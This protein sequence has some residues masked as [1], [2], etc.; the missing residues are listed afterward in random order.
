VHRRLNHPSR[1]DMGIPP[2]L[3]FDRILANGTGGFV[4]A[5]FAEVS[6]GSRSTSYWVRRLTESTY[7]HLCGYGADRFLDQGAALDP[8]VARLYVCLF[9]KA[10][11]T[12]VGGTES[13]G[14]NWQ[15]LESYD[16]ASGK[17]DHSLTSLRMPGHAGALWM[18]KLV[19]SSARANHVISTVGFEYDD[20][21]R[22]GARFVIYR[23]CEV[24]VVT[25]DLTVLGDLPG[26]FY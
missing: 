8:C 24:D 9:A 11:F 22:Q 16:L 4:V 1:E 23:I 14:Y 2:N 10:R 19:G 7:R 12:E 26:T 21:D 5:C 20:P 17:R 6:D 18:S 3:R 15:A 25:G 13:F